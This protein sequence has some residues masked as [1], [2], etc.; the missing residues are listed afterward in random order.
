M[1]FK[2]YYAVL[3]VSQNASREEIQR[4]FHKLARTYHPDV[5]KAPEAEE[6]F[7]E[8]NEAYE[9]LK[10][11]DKRARY[12]R[13]GMAWRAAQERGGTPPPGYEDVWVDVGGDREEVFSGFSRFFDQLFG[14][15]GRRGRAWEGRRVGGRAPQ[16]EWVVRGADREARITLTLEE[17]AHG[18][19]REMSLR[20]PATGQTKTY[21]VTI[22]KGI[23]PGQ[24]IRLAGQ[25]EPGSGGAPPGDLFLLVQ[26]YPHP[27]FRLEGT[28]LYTTLPLTPWEAALGTDVVLA[29]LDGT[30]TVT[31]PPGSSSGRILRLRGKGFPDPRSGPGDLYAE[32][33]IVVPEQPSAQE[34]RVYEELARVSPFRAE[35]KGG[36]V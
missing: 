24:R 21:T 32:I 13:Y 11:P 9:V 17:A 1:E 20:E 31:V 16:W 29:T 35:E 36:R 5:N 30:V 22:P 26:L 3:G 6:K 15:A 18:G 28:D 14:A 7:K 4:A 8:I 27:R 25:G 33:E 23:R 2:D 12:D 10:D 19:Q 34:R